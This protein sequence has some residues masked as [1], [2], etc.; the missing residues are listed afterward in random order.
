MIERP[1]P[2]TA[3]DE[4]GEALRAQTFS[5]IRRISGIGLGVLTALFVV[6]ALRFPN[7]PARYVIPAAALVVLMVLASEWLARR[8]R[9]GMA[10]HVYLA[11]LTVF[12]FSLAPFGNG[13]TGNLVVALVLVPVVAQLIRRGARRGAP[14]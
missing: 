8:K 3:L 11:A 1:V 6:L 5:F 13:V 14:C 9:P 2:I 4:Q 12:L 7:F 10:A